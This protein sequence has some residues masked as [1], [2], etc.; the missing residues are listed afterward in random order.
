MTRSFCAVDADGRRALFLMAHPGG[1][2]TGAIHKGKTLPLAEAIHLWRSRQWQQV[3][4]EPESISQLE[5][6]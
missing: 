6:Q 5:D 2:I 3:V 1:P 4:I